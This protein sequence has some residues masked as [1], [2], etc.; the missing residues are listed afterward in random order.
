[1]TDDFSPH[2]D[3]ERIYADAL[4]LR[5]AIRDAWEP[6]GF[7]LTGQGSTGQD[8]ENVLAR[9]LRESERTWRGWRGW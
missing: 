2:D 1:L 7:P 4:E 8:V 6:Q 9:M 3:L 5:D